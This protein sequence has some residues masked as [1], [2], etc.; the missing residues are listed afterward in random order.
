MVNIPMAYFSLRS[1]KNQIEYT[2]LK[3]KESNFPNHYFTIEIIN[4]NKV[5]KLCYKKGSHSSFKT[6]CSEKLITS[7][8]ACNIILKEFNSLTNNDVHRV[9]KAANHLFIKL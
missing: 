7:I 4:E 1:I 8:N 2:N 6:I 9:V 5:I 3:L